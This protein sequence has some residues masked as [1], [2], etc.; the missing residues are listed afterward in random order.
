[1]QSGLS[2]EHPDYTWDKTSPL[3]VSPSEEYGLPLSSVCHWHHLHNS[4]TFQQ[5]QKSLRNVY[6]S[7]L[8]VGNTF[9]VS[10]TV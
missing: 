2:P 9:V 7:R 8:A 3:R 4:D 10:N 6:G 1:M 5:L